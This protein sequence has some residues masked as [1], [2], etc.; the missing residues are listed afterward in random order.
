MPALAEA[1]LQLMAG[2][3]A[4]LCNRALLVKNMSD[5]ILT[6]ASHFILSTDLNLRLATLEVNSIFVSF[7]FLLSKFYLF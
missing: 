6:Q 5:Q 7:I 1:T 3:S 2:L 4:N